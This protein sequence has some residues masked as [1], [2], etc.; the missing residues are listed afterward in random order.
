M[1]KYIKL[2]LILSGFITIHA[3]NYKASE[4]KS[5]NYTQFE[6]LYDEGYNDS[7][8]HRKPSFKDDY[9][10]MQGYK[11]AKKYRF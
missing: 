10:Y 1:N 3:L 8:Y 5:Q 11:D 2:L 6:D 7:Y 9:E 4:L